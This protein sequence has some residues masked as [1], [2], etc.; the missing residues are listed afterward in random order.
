[1]E[2]IF[3]PEQEALKVRKDTA[4]GVKERRSGF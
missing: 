2:P 1:M 4:G 3:I